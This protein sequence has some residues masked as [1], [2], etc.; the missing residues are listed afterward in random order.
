MDHDSM[1][2]AFNTLVIYDIHGNSLQLLKSCFKNRQHHIGNEKI[3]TNTQHKI[4]VV[5][6]FNLGNLVFDDS[7]Q[8]FIL[9]FSKNRKWSAR[10]W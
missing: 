2:L 1:V 7:S 6:R 4:S 10:E 9:K 3:K 8:R 5:S